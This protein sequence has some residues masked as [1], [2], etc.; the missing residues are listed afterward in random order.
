MELVQALKEWQ[1]AVNALE[2]G[3]TVL[4]LRK[5]G[6][7]ETGGRFQVP[8]AQVLLYPTYEH[9][10]AQWLKPAYAGQVQPVASGWHPDSV[11]IG[12]WANITHVFP[13]QSAEMVAALL[14]FHVW[15]EAFVTERLRWKPQSPL[16]LLLLRVYRLPTA[17]QLPYVADYGGCKSWIELKAPIAVE[18]AM[19]VL[20]ETAYG[21]RVQ[22]IQNCMQANG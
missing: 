5:G 21:D 16:Y 1:V 2:Q 12:A 4:L 10:Q 19:P 17:V 15:N 14:P 6:I 8:F 7:R 3:E 9:Q 11:R 13:V 18:Q 22:Q 20:D